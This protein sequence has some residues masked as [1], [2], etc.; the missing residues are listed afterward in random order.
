MTSQ[1]SAGETDQQVANLVLQVMTQKEE[2]TA[3][4]Q[5]VL[6]FEGQAEAVQAEASSAR[7]LA[8]EAKSAHAECELQLAI[9]R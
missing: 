5:R 1:G 4:K 6:R 3:L 9:T 7:R 2:C 8:Q